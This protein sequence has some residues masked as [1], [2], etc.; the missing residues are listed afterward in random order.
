MIRNATHARTDVHADPSLFALTIALSDPAATFP[1]WRRLR[2]HALNIGYGASSIAFWTLVLLYCS[3]RISATL[4]LRS[5][6]ATVEGVSSTA[7]WLLR[8]PRVAAPR[9]SKTP[10]ESPQYSA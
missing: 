7:S 2:S 3:I 6:E 10:P 5:A 9:G 4:V 1:V 8:L